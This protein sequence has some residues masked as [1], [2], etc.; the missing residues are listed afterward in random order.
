MQLEEF[1]KKKAAAAAKKGTPLSTPQATPLHTPVKAPEPVSRKQPAAIGSAVHSHPSQSQPPANGK[2]PDPPS[3]AHAEPVRQPQP[4]QLTTATH[5]GNS[6]VRRPSKDAGENSTR[7]DDNGSAPAGPALHEQV[8][9]LQAQLRAEQQRH[10]AEVQGLRA[11]LQSKDAALQQSGA[12]AGGELERVRGELR[13]SEGM[14]QQLRAQAQQLQ[15]AHAAQLASAQESS[16]RMAEALRGEACMF[17]ALG[18]IAC[19]HWQHRGPGHAPP[20]MR[21]PSRYDALCLLKRALAIGTRMPGMWDMCKG[22]LA[23]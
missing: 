15:E 13:Q 23:V 1:K 20:C 19:T 21:C 14:V 4:P 16:R 8:A 5:D 12:Q 11:E 22:R 3:G 2:Q 7:A 18:P 6:T 10:A 17:P 9:E